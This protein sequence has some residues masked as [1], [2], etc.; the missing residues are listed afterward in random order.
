MK[1]KPSLYAPV[2]KPLEAPPSSHAAQ[3]IKGARV[4]VQQSQV[5]EGRGTHAS[6]GKFW[7]ELQKRER[8]HMVLD[9]GQS[10]E[11]TLHCEIS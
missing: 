3:N 2:W 6:R 7:E 8:F 5:A 11:N 1:G 4:Q 9:V 10:E